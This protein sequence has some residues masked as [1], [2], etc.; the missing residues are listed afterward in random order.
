MPAKCPCLVDHWLHVAAGFQGIVGMMIHLENADVP[1]SDAAMAKMEEQL[2]RLA[3][4]IQVQRQR[5]ENP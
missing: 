5:K 2:T 4:R 1:A 3:E